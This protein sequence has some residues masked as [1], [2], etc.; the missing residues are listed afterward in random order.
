MTN[1]I[2]ATDTTVAHDDIELVKFTDPSDNEA[3]WALFTDHRTSVAIINQEQAARDMAADGRFIFW[4]D[5]Q[6]IKDEGGDYLTAVETALQVPA[7][8]VEVYKA[9]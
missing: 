6:D 1:P 7:A 5:I 3:T 2:K 8:E 4:D 9:A